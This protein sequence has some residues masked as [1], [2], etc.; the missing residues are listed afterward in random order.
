MATADVKDR[1]QELEEKNV[2][3][4]A[5][6]AEIERFLSA[7]PPEPEPTVGLDPEVVRWADRC[8]DV[9]GED[10]KLVDRVQFRSRSR[11][12]RIVV[13]PKRPQFDSTGMKVGETAGSV[14][15]FQNGLY[16]TDDPT[17]VWSLMNRA[18]FQREFQRVGME[19]DRVP[20][21][22]PVIDALV[23][24]AIE[25]DVGTIEKILLAERGEGGHQRP[26]VITLGEASLR[27]IAGYEDVK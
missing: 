17:Y 14:A 9:I 15:E 23:K 27:R 22:Q 3:L 2:E 18:S 26:D 21:S 25:L 12:L 16:E 6:L 13:V 24:A 1:E 11:R 5:R 20:D 4:E 8:G 10:G 19:P 7:P